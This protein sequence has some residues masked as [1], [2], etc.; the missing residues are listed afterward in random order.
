MAEFSR[1]IYRVHGL[2]IA[3]ELQFPELAPVAGDFRLVPDLNVRLVKLPKDLE[4]FE[5]GIPDLF[6]ARDKLLLVVPGVARFEIAHGTEVAIEILDNA[7]MA[8]LRLFFFGSVMGLICHQRGLLPL[9]ASAVAFDGQAVA[10]CGP[11]GMGKST[12]AAVCVEAG[13]KLVA[14]DVLI[15]SNEVGS[16]TT[17]NPGM[18][19]IKLWR[20]AIEALGRTTEGLSPDWMR[21]EKFHVPF[22]PFAVTEPVL[23]SQ[24]FILE[25]EENAGAG[26]MTVLSGSDAVSELIQNTYRPEYLDI[27]HR[28]ATHF[29]DCIRLSKLTPVVRLRRRRDT[30]ELMKTALMLMDRLAIRS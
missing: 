3:S 30:A 10:F 5:T 26:A 21:A 13:A 28:R 15:A 25:T 9:H 6:F 7:D 11:A 1:H 16:H 23:L 22:G 19:K 27:A 17:I 24:I 20:D 12:L 18:P 4:T 29:A 14:D 8:L 2:V